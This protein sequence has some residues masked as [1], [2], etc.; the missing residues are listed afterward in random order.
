M[1][2]EHPEVIIPPESGD[3][4]PKAAMSFLSAASS[5]GFGP[6]AQKAL[7]VFFQNPDIRYWDLDRERVLEKVQ[8]KDV[9]EKD[10]AGVFDTIYREYGIVKED[11]TVTYWGDKTPFLL[12]RMDWLRLLF[13]KA[14][15]IFLL[16]DGRDVVNSMVHRLGRGQKA[17]CDRWKIGSRII[18]NHHEDPHLRSVLIHYE[19][20]VSNS[21]RILRDLFERIGVSAPSEL[22]ESISKNDRDH[23]DMILEHHKKSKMAVDPSNIGLWRK[24]MSGEEQERVQ[25]ELGPMLKKLGYRS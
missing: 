2:N 3:A 9:S 25:K 14:L 22:G 1:I 7:S 18:L 10:L 17:S 15:F 8:K 13:P 12:F 23:G 24:E 16:R 19:E 20:M 6:R 11:K 5:K 4:I 21:E